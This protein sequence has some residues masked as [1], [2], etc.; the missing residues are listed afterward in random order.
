MDTRNEIFQ[1]FTFCSVLKIRKLF[2]EIIILVTN[3]FGD[4]RSVKLPKNVS[5]GIQRNFGQQVHFGSMDKAKIGVKKDL[6]NTK[7]SEICN[8]NLNITGRTSAIGQLAG[9]QIRLAP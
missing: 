3:V 7:K 9:L 2:F 5:D 1:F 6:K 4:M 8:S